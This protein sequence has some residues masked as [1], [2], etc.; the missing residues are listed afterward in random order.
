MGVG[1]L[2][3]FGFYWKHLDAK[4]Q[5][6]QTSSQVNVMTDPP[7]QA[8]EAPPLK[9][10]RKITI[11]T[12]DGNIVIDMKSNAISVPIKG[13]ERMINVANNVIQITTRDGDFFYDMSENRL[14]I[15]YTG[16]A[17]E[18]FAEKYDKVNISDKTLNIVEKDDQSGSVI[19]LVWQ[20]AE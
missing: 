3:L 2:L 18:M 6:A 7:K 15:P 4:S 8:V 11:P 12:K 20:N 16:K 1:I 5:Q 17:Q 13:G 19:H 14:A 10:E 9:A